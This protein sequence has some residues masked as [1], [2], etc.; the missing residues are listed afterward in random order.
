MVQGLVDL[1]QSDFDTA[2]LREALALSNIVLD[3]FADRERG[4]Y[5]TTGDGHEGLIARTKNVHD[6]ALPSGAGVQALN[7]LRLSQLTGDPELERKARDVMASQA[8]LVNRHPRLFAHLLMAV[9]HVAQA[10]REVVISG[11]PG[12]PGTAA[13]L[14]AVRGVFVPQ[15]VVALASERADIELL[16]LLQGRGSTGAAKAYVCRNHTCAAPVDNAA[17][18]VHA[19]CDDVTS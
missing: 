15:R 16:P 12:D 2:W 10:A 4:G 11:E 3:R 7:L 13:L 14:A 17:A 18:L 8:A 1:Y 5:Y 9:D 19:L 6:G